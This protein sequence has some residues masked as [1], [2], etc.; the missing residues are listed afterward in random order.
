MNLSLPASLSYKEMEE[1]E[2]IMRSILSILLSLTLFANPLIAIAHTGHGDELRND[3]NVLPNEGV[4]VDAAIAEKIGIKV[5]PITK[6]SL[7]IAIRATG[8][9]ELLPNGRAKVT[10]PIKGTVMALMVEPGAKVQEAIANI[11]SS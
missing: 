1:Q 6:K 8:Q 10:T 2:N 3:A 4:Q 9:I 11:S 7:A 5:E